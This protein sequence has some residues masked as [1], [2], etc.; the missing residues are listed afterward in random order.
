MK[1]LNFGDLNSRLSRT[2]MKQIMAGS[3]SGS[4]IEEC[5]YVGSQCGSSNMCN[6]I[7]QCCMAQCMGTSC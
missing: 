7:I 3:G 1:K 2:E 5:Q 4:C 6:R